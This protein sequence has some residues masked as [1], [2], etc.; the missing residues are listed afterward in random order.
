MKQFTIRFRV[1]DVEVT[2][3]EPLRAWDRFGTDP[4][5]FLPQMHQVGLSVEEPPQGSAFRDPV[6]ALLEMLTLALGI[7]L[8][9]EVALGP[10]LTVQRD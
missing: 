4:D 5:R 10:L 6:I 1:N 9:R 8:P 2:S 7:R 3:F